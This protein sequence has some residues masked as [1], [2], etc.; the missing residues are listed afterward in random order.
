MTESDPAGPGTLLIDGG[1]AKRPS[2]REEPGAGEAADPLDTFTH[3][4]ARLSFS[5]ALSRD[6]VL[7]GAPGDLLMVDVQTQRR[8]PPVSCWP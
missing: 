7:P 8:V 6:R 1:I 3:P 5:F 4:R 2:T